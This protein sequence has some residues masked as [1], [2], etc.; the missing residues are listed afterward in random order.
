M[1]DIVR[2]ELAPAG[3]LRAAINLGNPILAQGDA[4]H[5]RG[6]TVD[7]ATELARRLG[8]RVEFVCVD[9]A[10]KSVEAVVEGR[11]DV[12]FLAIDPD[13]ADRLAFTDPYVLIEGMFAVPDGSGIRSTADVDRAGVRVGVKHGS[14]YDLHLS[15]NL[16]RAEVVRGDE[17][18]QV[19]A[20]QGLEVAAGIR[21]P[22]TAFVAEHGGMRLIEP[23]FMEI[24]QA[25]AVPARRSQAVQE[26]LQAFVEELKAS[27]FVAE[28]LERSGQDVSVAP[29]RG[30]PAHR[31]RWKG[32]LLALVAAVL[33]VL[34]AFAGV[35]AG[36]AWLAM[37]TVPFFGGAML[38]GAYQA[39][40]PGRLLPPAMVMLIGALWSLAGAVLIIASVID[41][42]AVVPDDMRMF[43]RVLG[44]ATILFFGGGALAVLVQTLRR[45]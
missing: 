34:G 23:P 24:A 43:A 10:R 33:V 2:Q 45:R 42:P 37:L 39:V 35:A 40:R 5:P 21:Q 9:A 26:Y 8:V 36:Q 12:G 13:R 18:T 17:G 16:D 4:Q 32:V 44:I 1:N 3:V 11:A 19:F 6:V 27:G 30:R 7:L 15:R 20:E 31:G 28:A 38:V 41:A 25:V 29:T 22:L 14:A